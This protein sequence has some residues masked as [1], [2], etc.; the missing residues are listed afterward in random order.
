MQAQLNIDEYFVDELIVKKNAKFD[1][2]KPITGDF[3]VDFDILN[4]KDNP[5][6]FMITMIIEFNKTNHNA[7]YYIF[8]KL[9]GFFSYNEGTE[10]EYIKKTLALN[11]PSILYGVAR[12]IIAQVSCN[13]EYGKFIIP[14]VNFVEILKRKHQVNKK[15]KK[16]SMLVL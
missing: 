1:K 3:F 6:L 12:G 14:A 8:I 11:A 16:K 10:E 9:S 5:R 7:P 2:N 15:P 4:N 13:Y